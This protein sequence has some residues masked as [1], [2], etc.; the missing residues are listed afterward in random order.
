VSK[1]GS[2][3]GSSRGGW[4]DS[5]VPEAKFFDKSIDKDYMRKKQRQ[6]GGLGGGGGFSLSNSRP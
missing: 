2:R 6:A 1:G 4:N 3:A 5:T